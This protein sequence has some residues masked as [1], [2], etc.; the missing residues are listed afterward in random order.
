MLALALGAALVGSSLLVPGAAQAAATNLSQ[1]K[2]ATASSVENADYTPASAA[3]DGDPGTRWASSWADPQWIMVDLGELSSIER[4]DLTW[5]SA[6]ATAYTIEVSD[7]GTSGWKTIHTSTAGPGGVESL[8]V[9]G[10]GRFVRLTGTTRSSGYGYSLWE[11]QVFG[12][13]GGVGNPDP[14]PEP[15][16]V[17]PGHPNQP[18]PF[19]SASVVEVT[20]GNGAW[21]LS[22]DGKPF[23]V[24]G[25]TWGPPIAEADTYMPGLVATGANTTRTWGTGADTKTL[26]DSAARHGVRVINGFWL[27]PGGGPGSGGCINYTTDEKYKAEQKADILNWV[28]TYKS[29][30]ATLM[31]SVGNESLLGLQN[32]FS[33]DV[34]EAERNAYAAYINE[35]AVAIKAIDP[36][37]PVTSTDAWTGSWPYYKANTPALDLLAVNSY[38]DVCNIEQT[39]EDGDYDWPYIVTEGGAAGEWEVPDD[40]NGVPNEPTDVEKAEALVDSWRCI[41]GHEGVGLGATFFHYGLEGDFGGVWFNVNPGDNKRPSYYAVA[42]IWNGSAQDANSSP[43]IS[44]MNIPGSTSIVAGEPFTFQLAVSD[45]DG[46]PLKYVT[47]FNSKYIDGAGGVEYVEHQRSGNDITVV[48]PQKL[49]VW[50]AYV[51]VEDGKGNVGV[52]TR[53]FRVVPP[54]VNGTNVAVGKSAEASSFQTWGDNYTPARAFDGDNATRWSSEWGNTGSIT[55]DLGQPTSFD[56][57]QLVWEAAFAKSYEVQTSNDGAT[58]ATIKT[59]TGENG[60]IDSFDAAGTARY[61]RLNLTERGTDWGFS[62]YEVGIYRTN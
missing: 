29:H 7:T 62:L 46:D 6:H 45:P 10:E 24:K 28:E 48:A 26:L 18:G 22:V 37:H 56:K 34:L 11:F 8:S 35:V 3:F 30:P 31:W 19:T 61:V 9:E 47:F 4:V 57:F 14:E 58:W 27:A 42:D 59:V 44:S 55:V 12:E 5:E 33:G 60:G 23:T 39:W 20:G 53:S 17:D 1:G 36:N 2:V 52:E 15:G 54:A 38:G 21:D 13:T 40:I 41:I 32:C 25:F 43:R 51:F 16:D 50:K 49:G